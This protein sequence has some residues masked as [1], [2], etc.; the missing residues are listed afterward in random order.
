[1]D[2]V[3]AAPELE[4]APPSGQVFPLGTTTVVCAAADADGNVTEG[5]FLVTVI[6]TTAPVLSLPENVSVPAASPDG[7][8]VTFS[9]TAFDAVSGEVPVVCEPASGTLFEVG[10]T[11]VTCTAA[12][13]AAGVPGVAGPI[14]PT[15]PASLGVRGVGPTPF[16][17]RAFDVTALD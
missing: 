15:G 11:E 16:G 10:T 5:Q 17:V 13:G 3:D 4:C 12:D 8:V 1:T 14:G 2:D 7:A 6:D 9:A